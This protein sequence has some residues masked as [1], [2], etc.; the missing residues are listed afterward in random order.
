MPRPVVSTELQRWPLHEPFCIARMR[1]DDLA[2]LL[3]R[4]ALG[5]VT[6][7]GE[8]AG[9]DYLGDLPMRALVEVENLR[10]ARP[11]AISREGLLDALPAG[12]ARN[13]LDCALWD[14]DCKTTGRSIWD[15]TDS[16]PRPVQTVATIGI[17]A[18]DAMARK[19]LD[20]RHFERLKLKLEQRRIDVLRAQAA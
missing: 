1:Y 10:D 3:V 19:A 16:S 12:G 5:G 7:R 8:A 4:V 11:H 20:L 2:V 18:P 17:G 6:G 15:L 13:A 9:V 14:L